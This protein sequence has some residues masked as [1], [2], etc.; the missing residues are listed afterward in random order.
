LAGMQY[1]EKME[2]CS[3]SVL[4]GLERI[5]VAGEGD[6]SLLCHAPE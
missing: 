6:S 2:A 1:V 4:D 3:M 5:A